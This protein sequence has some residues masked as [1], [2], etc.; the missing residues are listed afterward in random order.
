MADLI[1][2]VAWRG[3]IPFSVSSFN[4]VDAMVLCQILYCN[5]DGLLPCEFTKNAPTLREA[6]VYFA[7]SEDFSKRKD[8]G[9]MINDRTVYLLQVASESTRFGSIKLTGFVNKI[10]KKN[11]EQF[12]AVTYLLKNKGAFVAFR[13]TDDTVVGW[14]E[15]FDLGWKKEIPAQTDSLEYLKNAAASLWGPIKVAGHSKGGNLAIYACACVPKAIQ[16]RISEIYDF[17]GPGFKKDFLNGKGYLGIKDKIHSYVP[18]QSLVGMLFEHDSY[19]TI[20]STE[21]G[22][23]Q[24]DPLSWQ[25]EAVNFVELPDINDE[26]KLL[27]KTISESLAQLSLKQT[28][29][30]VNAVFN[31]LKSLGSTNSQIKANPLNSLGKAFKASAELDK[32]TKDCVWKVVQLLFHNYLENVRLGFEKKSVGKKKTDSIAKKTAS[33]K[34]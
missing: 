16:K 22:V 9:A 11:D 33:S 6:A 19:T 1:D 8:V 34:S 15:D 12:C 2:Y 20:E 21:N 10:D 14:K 3:D 29:I 5:F 24:H 25:V 17:D 32:Q 7:D 28:E 13:G 30:F 18:Q 4:E 27:K 26:A 31:I 23:M